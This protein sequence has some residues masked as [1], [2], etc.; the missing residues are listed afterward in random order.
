VERD[1]YEDQFQAERPIMLHS[2]VSA[3]DANFQS[4]KQDEREVRS[5]FLIM[6]IYS[7]L[8]KEVKTSTKRETFSLHFPSITT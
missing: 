8:I 2:Q 4:A 5:Y 3:L 7:Q 6:H 1:N